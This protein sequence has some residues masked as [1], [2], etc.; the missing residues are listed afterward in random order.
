[1]M[2]ERLRQACSGEL[3]LVMFDLDGT[4][5]DSLPDLHASCAAMLQNLG[6]S[7]PT[8]EAVSTWVGNGARQLVARALSGSRSIN[9][10]LTD[11]EITTALDLFKAHYR[12]MNG[13]YSRTYPGATELLSALHDAGISTAIVTNKP[14]EFSETLCAQLALPCSLL[15]GGDSLSTMKP[16]PAPL[17]HCLQIFGVS[18]DQAVMIGDSVND[19]AAAKAAGVAAVAV[20]Y[21]Y[22]HGLPLPAEDAVCVIDSLQELR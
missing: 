10:A 2:F 13:R 4:L 6:H 22:N 20:S 3:R 15:L 16:D 14:L 12:S 21:G 19:L 8:V 11:T 5:V 1:M 17:L 18:A 9:P 7:A